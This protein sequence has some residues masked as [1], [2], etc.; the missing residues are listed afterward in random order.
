MAYLIRRAPWAAVLVALAILAAYLP[1]QP[2]PTPDPYLGRWQSYPTPEGRLAKRLGDDY[3]Q[4]AERTYMLHLRDSL[5]RVIAARQV[6]PGEIAALAPFRAWENA[7]RATTN[8]ARPSVAAL[9]PDVRAAFALVAASSRDFWTTNNIYLPLA[10]D[11]HT[12][13]AVQGVVADRGAVP[14]TVTVSRPSEVLGPCG[15]FA[16]FGLPGPQIR[17]WLE[18]REYDFAQ[19]ADWQAQRQTPEQPERH[20]AELWMQ[21]A[22]S[23]LGVMNRPDRM[24]SLFDSPYGLPISATGCA[25]GKQDACRRFFFTDSADRGSPIQNV[26]RVCYYCFSRRGQMLA[27]L[28]SEQGPDRFRKFWQSSLPP[29]EAFDRSFSIPFA[30][31]GPTWVRTTYGGISVDVVTTLREVGSSVVWTLLCAGICAGLALTRRVA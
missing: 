16:A 29:E 28:V 27:T 15:F 20:D 26:V 2:P 8:A 10:T 4:V 6:H 7:S 21:L 23:R 22:L 9:S 11:G 14:K 3:A 25:V 12:C 30:R 13:L 1:P 24:P 18:A 19:N 17:R 5:M 31:W